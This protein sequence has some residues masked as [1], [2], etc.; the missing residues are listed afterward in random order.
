M[1]QN[2][3]QQLL[4]AQDIDFTENNIL[5]QQDN[6]KKVVD[7]FLSATSTSDLE[8][9]YNKMIELRKEETEKWSEKV[10]SMIQSNR[11]KNISDVDL[12]KFSMQ[13]LEHHINTYIERNDVKLKLQ[14]FDF[15][16]FELFNESFALYFKDL[17]NKEDKKA[18]PNDYVDFMNLVYCTTEY[19]YLT[20]EKL[21]GN[22][23]VKM[24]NTSSVGYKYIIPEEE[25][26][27]EILNR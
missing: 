2:D 24:I 4:I 20:L 27:K 10:N 13:I 25:N 11:D 15:S 9:D 22:R 16:I 3:A 7:L 5:Q 8:F 19:K 26:I 12:K 21:K 1:S 17:L 23:I 18:K 14:N 6:I